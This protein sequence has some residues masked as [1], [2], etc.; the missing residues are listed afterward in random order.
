MLAKASD[1]YMAF[2]YPNLPMRGCL[3]KQ[4]NVSCFCHWLVDMFAIL[5]SVHHCFRHWEIC[6]VAAL[7][8]AEATIAWIVVDQ[9][10][11]APE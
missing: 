7:A 9:L 5:E 4:Q 2:G 1:Q 10:Y 6:F 11:C 3:A 8:D